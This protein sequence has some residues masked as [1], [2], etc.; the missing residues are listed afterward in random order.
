MKR[1]LRRD[2]DKD[3]VKADKVKEKLASCLRVQCRIKRFRADGWE[4]SQKPDFWKMFHTVHDQQ[5]MDM[6]RRDLDLI[7]LGNTLNMVT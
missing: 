6:T 3:T 7:S 4:L 5:A 2:V 1:R